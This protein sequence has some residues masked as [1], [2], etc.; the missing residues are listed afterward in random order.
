MSRR[1]PVNFWLLLAATICVDAV[2]LSWVIR[3]GVESYYVGVLYDALLFSQL[4]V[5]CVWATFAA[6]GWLRNALVLVAVGIVAAITTSVAVEISILETI[7]IVGT[8]FTWLM[9]LLWTLKHSK[10]W[11][12][13]GKDTTSTW[14]FSTA[15]LLGLMSIIGVLVTLLRR[16]EL[17]LEVGEMIAATLVTTGILVT[18]IIVIWV[19]PWHVVMRLAASL[20]LGALFGLVR[21]AYAVWRADPLL[22]ISLDD[23]PVE[24]P[25]VLIEIL[26]LVAWL[27]WGQIMRERPDAS[28]SADA[29]SPATS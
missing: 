20:T 14:Q 11:Q 22:S 24:I 10:Y 27:Q 23:L 19:M 28:E 17:A 4:S 15:Q 8:Y 9:L 26:V 6:R 7:T 21:W 25:N 3:D 16:S 2:V 5:A 1:G 13:R 29:R 18:A 12:S